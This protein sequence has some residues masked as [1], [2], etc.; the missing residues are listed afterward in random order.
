[1]YSGRTANQAAKWRSEHCPATCPWIFGFDTFTGT[2]STAHIA[3]A[4]YTCAFQQH[5]TAL[6]RL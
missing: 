3:A 2:C 6:T 5:P 1:M 4:I